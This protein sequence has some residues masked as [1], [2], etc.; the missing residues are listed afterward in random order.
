MLCVC[1][2][3]VSA[4]GLAGVESLLHSLLAVSGSVLVF[5]PLYSIKKYSMPLAY[6]KK[7][8]PPAKTK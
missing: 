3:G 1:F 6:S 4:F 5:K 8:T 7:K 2:V